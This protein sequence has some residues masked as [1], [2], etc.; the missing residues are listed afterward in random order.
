MLNCTGIGELGIGIDIG[1]ELAGEDRN[2]RCTMES[3]L[4]MAEVWKE[5]TESPPHMVIEARNHI[6]ESPALTVVIE[7]ERDRILA[8]LTRSEDTITPAEGIWKEEDT[9]EEKDDPPPPPIY[10]PVQ[11]SRFEKG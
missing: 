8:G 3:P 2:M 9:R 5:N 4:I 6:T 10:P 11:I 1:I 7:V